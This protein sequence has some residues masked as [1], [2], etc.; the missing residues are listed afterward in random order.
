MAAGGW[1]CEHSQGAGEAGSRPGRYVVSAGRD[2]VNV[3]INHFLTIA[4]PF[5]NIR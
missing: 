1:G 4:S 3:N 5:S 2:D